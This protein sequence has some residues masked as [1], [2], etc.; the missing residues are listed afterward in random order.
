VYSP[1]TTSVFSTTFSKDWKTRTSNEPIYIEDGVEATG[2]SFAI[3]IDKAVLPVAV[4]PTTHQTRRT[5]AGGSLTLPPSG[6][7]ADGS[8]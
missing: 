6:P 4:G 3:E 7:T 1:K 5:H 8:S 2:A